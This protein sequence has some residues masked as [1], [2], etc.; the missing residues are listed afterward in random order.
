[1]NTAFGT[2]IRELDRRTHDGI[3]VRLLWNSQ[4]DQVSV[5]VEDQRGGMSFEFEVEP[6]DARAAFRHPFAYAGPYQVDQPL[7]A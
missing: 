3:D 1:M 7:A 4:T 2:P 5:V 6:A